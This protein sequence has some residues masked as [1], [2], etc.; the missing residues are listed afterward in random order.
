MFFRGVMEKFH[1][2]KINKNTGSTYDTAKSYTQ[3][4]Q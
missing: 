2:P 4:V 1:S 3:N